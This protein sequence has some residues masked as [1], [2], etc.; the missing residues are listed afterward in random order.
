MG[1]NIQTAINCF[2]EN[3]NLFSHP[4]AEPEKYNLYQGL[5]YLAKT[6]KEI[7]NDLAQIKK[8]IIYLKS[9]AH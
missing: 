6:I 5:G 1:Q 2:V 7:E 3:M 4:Q 9:I 8:E